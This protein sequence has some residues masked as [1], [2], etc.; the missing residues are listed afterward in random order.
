MLTCST[1]PST[2]YRVT[3][4]EFFCF[5]RIA[6]DIAWFSTLGFHCG[7]IMKTRFADVRFRLYLVV[8]TGK[9]FIPMGA[10]VRMDNEV[11]YPNA[12]VPVVI[13]RT[14]I[15][16]S[17]ENRFRIC[18]RLLREQLPSILLKGIDSLQRYLSTR[19]RVFVQQENTMLRRASDCPGYS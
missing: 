1:V 6:L 9:A 17:A 3:M 13:M 19:S 5:S 14:G 8:S 4:T 18:C 2:T 11:A 10:T 12:P 16:E 7:S 15:E